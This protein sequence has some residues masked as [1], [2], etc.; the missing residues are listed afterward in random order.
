MSYDNN[1]L[2]ANVNCYIHFRKQYSCS[3]TEQNRGRGPSIKVTM[4]VYVQVIRPENVEH[5]SMKDKMETTLPVTPEL[6]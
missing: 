4:I 6:A 3:T 2:V 5:L 1:S